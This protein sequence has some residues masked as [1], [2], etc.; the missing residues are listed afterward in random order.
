[1]N[2]LV[3]A[4]KDAEGLYRLTDR[5]YAVTRPGAPPEERTVGD[6]EL[7]DLLTGLFRVP[8]TADELAQLTARLPE[9]AR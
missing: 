3:V 1:M 2:R 9:P 4:R 5:V 7:A 8:L 6:E